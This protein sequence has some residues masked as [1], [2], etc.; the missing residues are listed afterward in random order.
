MMRAINPIF[1]AP[2]LV[3]RD[4]GRTDLGEWFQGDKSLAGPV[5]E[6]WIVDPANASDAGPLGR[7]IARQSAGMLGDLGRAPP[8]VRLVFP[9]EPMSIRSTSPISFW[10]VL[11]PGVESVSGLHGIFHRPGDRMR[12]YEG[13]AVSLAAGSVALEVSS[14]FLPTNEADPAPQLIRLPPVSMRM[15]ATQFREAGL[16]VETWLLP[17][18]S[19]I[20]PDGETCHVL[21]PLGADIRVDG[22]AVPP[23]ESVFV[24]A[25]GRPLD[26]TAARQGAKLLVAYPDQAPTSI[27]RHTPG[28]DPAAGQLP[29][30]EPA[31]PPLYAGSTLEPAMAA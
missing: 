9:G 10:T 22:R 28:P 13:A 6:A 26:L 29:K 31:H 20:V 1:V 3:P 11:E 23:G 27:W 8:K 12:A 5:A 4:W 2:R 25:C 16:S 7:S 15:R 24:P 14:S 18:W 17:E 30:P 19:R 21:V